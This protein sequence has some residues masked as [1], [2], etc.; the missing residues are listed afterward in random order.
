[1]PAGVNISLPSYLVMNTLV[2]RLDRGYSGVALPGLMFIRCARSD[3]LLWT[4]QAEQQS[5]LEL[6]EFLLDI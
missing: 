6:G 4:E 3:L 1:M 2:S 5:N